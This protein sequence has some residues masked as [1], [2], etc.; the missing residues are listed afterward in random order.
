[1]KVVYHSVAPTATT[2]RNFLLTL[3]KATSKMLKY[4]K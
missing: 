2:G 4:T 1:M 3:D